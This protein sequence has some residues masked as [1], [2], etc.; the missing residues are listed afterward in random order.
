MAAIDLNRVATAAAE[1]FLDGQDQSENGK[2][3]DGDRGGGGAG[4]ILG[5]GTLAIG[6]GLALAARAAYH[7]VRSMDLDRLAD[8]V[9]DRIEGNHG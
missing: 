6:A 3:D 7:R 2:V 9:E 1:A 5:L 8:A 4:T